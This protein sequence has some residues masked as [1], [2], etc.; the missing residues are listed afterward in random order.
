MPRQG[1]ASCTIS[2]L[3]IRQGPARGWVLADQACIARGSAV[4]DGDG[5]GDG[6]CQGDGD[7]DETE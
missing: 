3:W 1:L 5:D 6:D 2:R 7:G 4:R